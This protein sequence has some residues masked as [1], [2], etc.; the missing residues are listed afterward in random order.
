MMKGRSAPLGTASA[1]H[2]VPHDVSDKITCHADQS[3]A[4][5]YIQD[6]MVKAMAEG[7]N[8]V[9]FDPPILPGPR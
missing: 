8:R 6:S 9:R 2:G 5:V 1:G 3:V 7:L 4:G